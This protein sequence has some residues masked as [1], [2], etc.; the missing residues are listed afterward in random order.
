[1][2]TL[3]SNPLRVLIVEDDRDLETL[4][5]QVLRTISSSVEVDWATNVLDARCKLESK[6]YDLVIADHT[7]EDDLSGFFLRCLCKRRWPDLPFVMISA[8][9]ADAFLKMSGS[10]PC[11]FL[12]KPFTVQ[13]CREMICSALATGA[14]KER[15]V[16][17]IE[18]DPDYRELVSRWL[19]RAPDVH[20]DCTGAESVESGLDALNRSRYDV[21]LLDLALPDSYGLFTLERMRNQHG[22]VPV[23][24]LSATDDEDLEQRI[25]D[26]GA[27]RY[28][29]KHE[30]DAR[31]LVRTVC[32]AVGA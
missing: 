8:M 14:R 6:R 1:M 20:F 9:R 5:S 21:V 26:A 2:E 31:T 32:D 3:A 13:E 10:V 12:S 25:L 22:D 27:G 7:L 29:A 11:P 28:V 4:L 16:L 18:D 17:L 30:A 24:V 15:S 19:E 23:I